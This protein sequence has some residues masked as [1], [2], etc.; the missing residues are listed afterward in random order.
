MFA[1]DLIRRAADAGLASLVLTVDVPVSSKRERNIRN[2]FANVRGGLF[3]AL[4]S[5]SPST[6]LSPLTVGLLQQFAVAPASSPGPMLQSRLL[7]E[8]S[9]GTLLL[10]RCSNFTAAAR[11]QR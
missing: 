6:P 11:H 8:S 3:Q 1:E 4:K 5:A 9:Y 7:A 10:F 2:G